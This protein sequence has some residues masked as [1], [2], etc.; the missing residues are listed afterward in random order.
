M[1]V[2]IS[3]VREIIRVAEVTAMPKAPK[4]LEG[5]INLRSR[6]IPVLDL[7]RR[8][9]M[10]LVDPTSESRILVVEIK[11]QILGFLVDKVI[12][13]LKVSF[14]MVSPPKGRILNVGSEFI[15]EVLALDHRQILSLN[16]T[17]LFAFDEV[18]LLSEPK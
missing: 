11:D 18:K 15:E 1:S 12:E 8:F 14:A 17:K 13:V 5:V 2:E 16:L 7:K 4:Y 10:P 6:I 9:D 3:H